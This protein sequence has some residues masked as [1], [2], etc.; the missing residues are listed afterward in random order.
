MSKASKAS[1][2]QARNDTDQTSKRLSE[3]YRL[4]CRFDVLALKPGNVSV[5]LAGH[6]MIA[7]QFLDAARVS[8]EPLVGEKS[9]G[10]SILKATKASVNAA[11]C[12]TNLGIVLLSAPLVIAAR[13][14]LRANGELPLRDRLTHLIDTST[15]ED[16]VDVYEAITI[17]EPGGLGSSDAHDV[18]EIPAITLTEAM[19]FAT[20]RD[21]IAYQYANSFVDIFTLG[22][23]IFHHFMY[24]WSSIKWATV[25]VYLSFLGSLNDTHIVRKYGVSVAENVRLE[26]LPLERAFKA[27]ENPVEFSSRLMGFDEELK[28]GGVNPG[29]SAD[30]TVASLLA[31]LLAVH[32]KSV[33][34]A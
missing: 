12:N 6:N 3:L 4:A 25:A 26:A 15:V 34:K 23:P 24:R 18:A 31:F 7:Q 27:C 28:R 20:E 32:L 30:L 21:R 17:A 16:T 29:T 10:Q 5:E 33:T 13:D 19:D 22:V 11:G 8:S 14:I 2:R 9:L 1:D